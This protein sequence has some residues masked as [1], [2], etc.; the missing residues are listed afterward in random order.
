MG[1]G[2]FFAAVRDTVEAIAARVTNSELFGSQGSMHNNVESGFGRDT[3]VYEN[4]KRSKKALAKRKMNINLHPSGVSKVHYRSMF[5]PPSDITEEQVA[6][7]FLRWGRSGGITN[8]FGG[9]GNFGIIV[10]GIDSNGMLI[11]DEIYSKSYV[12]KHYFSKLQVR[13]GNKNELNIVSCSFGG[14]DCYSFNSPAFISKYYGI[15]VVV[16]DSGNS[17]ALRNLDLLDGKHSKFYDAG[18]ASA[19]NINVKDGIVVLPKVY[20]YKADPSIL[21]ELPPIEFD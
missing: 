19:H 6:S 7:E 21:K 2:S 17:L 15:P 3:D 14:E 16:P 11:G 20:D 10:H 5:Q 12:I 18:E 4:I 9:S 1:M 8:N 13:F